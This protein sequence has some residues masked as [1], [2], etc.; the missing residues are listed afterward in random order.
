V[1]KKKDKIAAEKKNWYSDRYQWV[2][3]QRN[4][5]ALITL[6]SLAF[7]V[8]SI[9][10]IHSNIPLVTVEPFVIQMDP[11]SGIT[12][13]VKAVTSE[14]LTSNEAISN[15]FIVQYVRARES[16]G[17]D[18]KQN[19]Y[20]VRLMST[21][22]VFNDHSW[23]TNAN[24]PQSPVSR[25]GEAGARWVYFRTIIQNSVKPTPAMPNPPQSATIRLIVRERN[26][27]NS[28]TESHKLV[29]IQYEFADINLNQQQ[30][31]VN[32]LGFYVSAYRVDEDSAPQ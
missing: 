11:R 23:S 4:F 26:K 20:L 17:L 7:S 12:Q 25:L 14:E 18:Q 10:I 27:T 28:I 29:T 24:N 16:F 1:F 2:L 30:R 15:Y 22:D 6:L 9:W 8:V 19:D 31:F 5:L 21:D 13:V 3:V 32:P